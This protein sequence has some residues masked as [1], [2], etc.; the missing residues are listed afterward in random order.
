MNE[1]RCLFFS[2]GGGGTRRRCKL[3][4]AGIEVGEKERERIMKDREPS[5]VLRVNGLLLGVSAK[6]K[7]QKEIEKE[8]KE[9]E[10]EEK[11]RKER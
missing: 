5:H 3:K 2:G 8:E 11:R 9:R 6:A 7:Q 10:R 1:E 4:V